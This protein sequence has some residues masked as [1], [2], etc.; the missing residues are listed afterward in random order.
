M[1][2][3]FDNKNDS[4]F[5]VVKGELKLANSCKWGYLLQMVGGCLSFES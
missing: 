5:L 3:I 2:N 1:I 4:L